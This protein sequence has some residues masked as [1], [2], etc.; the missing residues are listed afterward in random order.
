MAGLVQACPGLRRLPCTAAASNTWMP[1]PGMR[2]PQ[3]SGNFAGCAKAPAPACEVSEVRSRHPYRQRRWCTVRA[4][5][6][7]RFG[8]SR[9]LCAPYGNLRFH[10]ARCAKG[11]LFPPK[12][13]KN[14]Q[15]F[16]KG[17]QPYR[18]SEIASNQTCSPINKRTIGPW[19]LLREA[20]MPSAP[21]TRG[22]VTLKL[23]TWYPCYPMTR[24]GCS[25]QNRPRY[26]APYCPAV[27]ARRR[28]R[29]KHSR[30]G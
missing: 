5:G 3:G 26:R 20:I 8:P 4:S 23:I 16:G 9:R 18:E 7:Y 28:S 21:G 17:L 13:R 24:R 30:S 25:D 14:F 2:V 15:Q 6:A 22:R 27:S 12:K 10:P 1:A 11:M 29:R 19:R